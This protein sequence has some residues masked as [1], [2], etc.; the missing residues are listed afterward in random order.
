MKKSQNR[1]SE[2]ELLQEEIE[3]EETYI[4]DINGGHDDNIAFIRL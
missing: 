4:Y 2:F 3:V 1:I